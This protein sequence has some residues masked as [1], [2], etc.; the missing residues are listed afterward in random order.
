MHKEE[1]VKLLKN[2]GAIKFGKFVL[3]SGAV[4]DYYIDI[5]KA[6]SNPQVLKKIG[7]ALA[8]YTLFFVIGNFSLVFSGSIINF[9]FIISH[10][11]K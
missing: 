2:C 1:L 5:K 7:E 11:S 6:N 3:T 8:K 4:S 10:L 9:T